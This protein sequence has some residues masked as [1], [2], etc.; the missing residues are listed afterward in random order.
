MIQTRFADLGYL[1]CLTHQTTFACLFFQEMYTST[2]FLF[3]VM[4]T[5]I[6]RMMKPCM[7]QERSARCGL[8]TSTRESFPL[9]TS[10]LHEFLCDKMKKNHQRTAFVSI[11]K[12]LL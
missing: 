12:Q 2:L 11:I 5:K 7:L 1:T 6:T 3:I 9:H 8:K 4:S 10:L